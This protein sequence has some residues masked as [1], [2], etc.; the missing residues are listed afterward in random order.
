MRRWRRIVTHRTPDN[1]VTFYSSNNVY[2]RS[3]PSQEHELVVEMFGVRPDLA[4]DV[5]EAMNWSVPKYE[6]AVVMEGDLTT[7]VPTEHRAD[8]VVKYVGA[9]DRAVFAVII[10]AQLRADARKHYAWPAYVSNLYARL[11]CP[12]LLVVVC[13]D[14]A[15]AIKCGEPVVITDPAFFRLAPVVVGPREVP[16]VTDVVTAEDNPEMAVLSTLMRRPEQGLNLQLT[17]T[18]AAIRKIHLNTGVL[19][20]DSLLAVLPEAHRLLLEEIVTTL[21]FKGDFARH[22][23]AVGES[24]G[25]ARTVLMILEARGVEVPED[26]R[27]TIMGCADIDQLD[28]W[29]RRSAT[30]DRIG[31]VVDMS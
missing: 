8:R 2:D 22:H 25:E 30:A 3:M 4:V 27:A 17:A 12:L 14:E 11:K 29:A 5:L 13:P 1:T 7:L 15:S 18:A 31:D 26:V 23:E 19:Y 10:E 21:G 24:R 6:E 20:Y 28:T 16:L 9:G